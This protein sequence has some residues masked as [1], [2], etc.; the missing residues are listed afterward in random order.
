MTPFMIVSEAGTVSPQGVVVMRLPNGVRFDG[1]IDNQ[2]T[3]TG[4]TSSFA[5]V[6][7][8]LWRKRRG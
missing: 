4:Q 6:T 7:T 3:I 5:C 8:F 1:Q 2:G